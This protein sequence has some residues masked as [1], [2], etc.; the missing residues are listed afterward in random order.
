MPGREKLTLGVRL[1]VVLT[2]LSVLFAGVVYLTSLDSE[3]MVEQVQSEIDR[4]LTGR[5]QIIHRWSEAVVLE[6][7]RQLAAPFL[8]GVETLEGVKEGTGEFNALQARMAQFVYGSDAPPSV[9]SQPVGPLESVLVVSPDYRIVASSDALKVDWRFT[10]QDEVALFEAARE[11]PQLRESPGDPRDD[12]LPVSELTV[13]V[14][15]A[16]GEL[17]GFV[18]L[19]YVGGEISGLPSLPEVRVKPEPRMIGPM[20]AGLVALLGVGF[21]ALATWQVIQLTRRIEAAARGVRLPR[22]RG[23]GGE[24]LSLIE[25]KLESLSEEV[26]RDDLLVESL[27]EALREGVVLLDP[28]GQPV[29]ANRQAVAMLQSPGAEDVSH[30]SFSALLELNPDLAMIVHHGIESRR[31]VRDKPLTLR[32]PAGREVAVQVTTYV[33]RDV[34]R[35]AGILVVLKDRK[36]IETLEKNLVEASK[37]Q[38]LVRLTGS[39]AHE[40]KNPL[41]AIGIHLEHLRRRL[42]RLEEIDR[43]AEERVD[44]LREEIDRLREILD[45]WLQLTAP[46]ERAP[47][48]ADISEVLDSVARLLRVE[49]RHQ[50]VDLIVDQ[51]G[52]PGRVTLSTARLRQVLLNLCLNGL[53]AMPDGGRLVLRACRT[54]DTVELRVEDSGDGIPED[55]HARVFDFHFTTRDNGSG[56]GLSICQRLVEAAGGTLS[57]DSEVGRGTV[58]T[59]RLP[60]QE[61]VRESRPGAPQSIRSPRTR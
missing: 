45:E 41:G 38:S 47:A 43:A 52:E 39:V 11:R 16:A 31:A 23:P 22:V 57:L 17:I 2:A 13:A 10:D 3:R 37:L 4:Q 42:R 44:V 32:I 46:E 24:A 8:W 1:G 6:H 27:T 25:E 30:A 54:G 33:M 61:A 56:L 34:E 5:R 36:S 50:G 7:A 60:V 29:T 20:L 59:I 14:P 19:R 48:H 40:V 53:Q 12:G 15:N 35:T 55:L 26:R 18:R 58:F 28:E 49:A 21:G 9:P 51:E